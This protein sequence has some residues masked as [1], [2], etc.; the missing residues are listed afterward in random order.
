MRK[1]TNLEKMYI[2]LVPYSESYIKERI[3]YIKLYKEVKANELSEEDKEKIQKELVQLLKIMINHEKNNKNI[4][5]ECI[6]II[7]NSDSEKD[8][9]IA[10]IKIN[11][12]L[13]KNRYNAEQI[14]SDYE[15]L[16]KINDSNIQKIIEENIDNSIEN[17]QKYDRC[18]ITKEQSEKIIEEIKFSEKLY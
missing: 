10:Y 11:E 15:Q 3:E 8:K 14:K 13:Q 16:K 4:I 7:N 17:I 5:S 6:E 18:R 2:Y 1:K 9:E 12:K